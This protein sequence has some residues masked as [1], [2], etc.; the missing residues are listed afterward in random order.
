MS[1]DRHEA[2]L[3]AARKLVYAC[4]EIR[5]SYV[6]GRVGVPEAL[7]PWWAPSRAFLGLIEALAAYE[8]E[9]GLR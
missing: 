2:E 7:A 8:R 9:I 4:V 3:R 6:A 1:G 5:R